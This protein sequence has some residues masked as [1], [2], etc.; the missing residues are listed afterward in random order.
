MIFKTP[1]ESL[2]CN[3]FEI[4]RHWPRMY[5]IESD[6]EQTAVLWAAW[7]KTIDC[8][9]LYTSDLRPR[10]EPSVLASAVRARGDW[11]VGVMNPRGRT[12][13]KEDGERLIEEYRSEGLILTGTENAPETGI[14]SIEERASTGRL[15]VFR[16]M[17]DFHAQ[18]R[19]YRRDENGKIDNRYDL[20]MDTLRGVVASY[21]HIATTQHTDTEDFGVGIAGDPSIGY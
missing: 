13:T 2:L 4:P 21:R 1:I 20:L 5:A 8:L 15:K 14:Q 3:P 9:Y 17:D 10:G 12:R 6:W 18:W 16:T 7:D 11:I 19:L